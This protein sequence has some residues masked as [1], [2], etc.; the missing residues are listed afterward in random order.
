[1]PLDA[2]V[3]GLVVEDEA[4]PAQSAKAGAAAAKAESME[5]ARTRRFIC[6]TPVA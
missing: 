6:L 1:M 2:V 5:K 4:I 3:V